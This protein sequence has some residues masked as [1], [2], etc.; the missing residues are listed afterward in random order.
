MRQ[1]PE[2]RF[3]DEQPI[4]LRIVAVYA[5]VLA[6]AEVDRLADRRE[7][8]KHQLAVRIDHT[9]LRNEAAVG[10][11]LLPHV[12]LKIAGVFENILAHV[13]QY[14]IHQADGAAHMRLEGSR[15]VH[16]ILAR[17]SF[18]QRTFMPDFPQHERP[19]RHQ[20]K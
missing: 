5:K 11:Q 18:G 20:R 3:A 17:G 13:Q 10:L 19:H 2:H 8:G 14:D 6:I 12:I 1:P 4:G 16:R 15:Q 9:Q 7:I